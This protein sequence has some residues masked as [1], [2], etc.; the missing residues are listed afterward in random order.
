MNFAFRWL[1][2][3]SLKSITKTLLRNCG[4]DVRLVRNIKNH[5]VRTWEEKQLD[6]W[7][8]FVGHRDI[9]TVI[10]IGANTGQFA[11]MVHR[12]CPNAKIYSFEPV[13][14]CFPELE[15]TLS[16]IPGARAFPLALGDTAT[17]TW[18]NRSRFTPCSSLLAGTGDLGEDYPDAA[19]V[20]KFEVHV[21]R[22]D[23]V[24]GAEVLEP[25]ILIKLDVQ[26]YEIP[27]ICGGPEI[28]SK[29]AIVAVEVCFFR[30]LYEN[31]PLFDEVYSVLRDRGFSYRGN[32]DQ[33]ARKLD[34][35]IVEADAI[36][37]RDG[38]RQ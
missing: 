8:P 35:R 33:M 10:D 16:G 3:M 5:A 36:F 19:V 11:A 24:L 13:P 6:M 4:L 21:V 23:D 1:K 9:R 15:R 18:M 38:E 37:E 28:I 30:R 12:L 22:L 27:A 20:D 17:K 31:Q 7:H 34:G 29:A 14:N 2:D 26:G 25:E 32:A